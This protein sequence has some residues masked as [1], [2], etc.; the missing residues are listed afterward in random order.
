MLKTIK[1]NKYHNRI[2]GAAIFF[3][4]DLIRPLVKNPETDS[5]TVEI[6]S[7]DV[8]IAILPVRDGA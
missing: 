4:A 8:G 1:L 5:I 6:E 7:N 2:L 3:N